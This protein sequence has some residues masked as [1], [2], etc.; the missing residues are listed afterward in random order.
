MADAGAGPSLEI[1]V[2][3]VEGRSR[4]EA[5]EAAGNSKIAG[6]GRRVENGGDGGCSVLGVREVREGEAGV[7]RGKRGAAYAATVHSG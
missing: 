1:M 6:R 5:D 3:S 2:V 7:A 4:G